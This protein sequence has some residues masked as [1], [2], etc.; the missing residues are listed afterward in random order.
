[1]WSKEKP[2]E[3]GRYWCHQNKISKIVLIWKKIDNDVN[4][5][6]DDYVGCLLTDRYYKGALWWSEKIVAPKDPISNLSENVED[7]CN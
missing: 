6:T 4:L 2:K 1:M 5:Y 3:K 7:K